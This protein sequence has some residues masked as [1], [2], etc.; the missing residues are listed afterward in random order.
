MNEDTDIGP[1]RRRSK[2][3]AAPRQEAYTLLIEVSRKPEDGL[4]P[5]CTGAALL[6]YASG[7]DEAEAVREAVAVLKQAGMAPLD[8]T[9][10]GTLP[11]RLRNG[12]EIPEAEQALIRRATAEN[13]VIVADVTPFYD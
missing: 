11:E 8:V 9:A 4:P 12:D 2:S 7:V 13:S 6:C 5:T 1:E 3:A 10:Y